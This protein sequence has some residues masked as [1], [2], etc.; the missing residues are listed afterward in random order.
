MSVCPNINLPE[1][2]ALEKEFGRYQAYRDFVESGY[3]IRT[4]QQVQNK[5]DAEK[6]SKATTPRLP[7]TK[8]IM[9]GSVEEVN[10]IAFNASQIDTNS[11]VQKMVRDSQITRAMEIARKLSENLGVNFNIISGER[12]T[13]ITAGSVNPWSGQ[14]A[15]YYGGVAYFVGDTLSLNSVLHEFAHPLVRQIQLENPTLFN[16]LYNKVSSTKEGRE[17]IEKLATTHPK[18]VPGDMMYAEEVLVQ[19][20]EHAATKQELTPSFI[21]AIKDFLF[22]LKKVLRNALGQIDVSKLDQNTTLEELA[23]MLRNDKFQ[24]DTELVTEEDVV[25]YAQSFQQEINELKNLDKS[26]IQDVIRDGYRIASRQLRQLQEDKNYK[27]LARILKNQ[28]QGFDMETIMQDLSKYQKEIDNIVNNAI[29][30]MEL[31][32]NQSTAVVNTVYNLRTI[33]EKIEAHM[34]DI[35]KNQDSKENLQKAV[36]YKKIVDYWEAFIDDLDTALKDPE[37][38]VPSNAKIYDVINNIRGRFKSINELTNT[39]MAN[40]ARDTLYEEFL[41]IVRDAEERYTQIISDLKKRGAPQRTI[42]KWYREYYGMTEAEHEVYKELND[43][44]N[45]GEYMSKSDKANYASLRLMSA[46]GIELTK[47]KMEDLLK[48]NIKD[49]NWLNSFMEGYM[50]NNDPVIG[51]LALYVKNRMNE[52]YVKAQAKMNAFSMDIRD[53]LKAMGYNPHNIGALG[54]VIMF[55]DNI[56]KEENGKLVAK[57]IW[58]FLN[59]FK[60]YRYDLRI[61]NR[62]VMDAEEEYSA[63]GSD[64]TLSR[65]YEAIVKRKDFMRKYFH[66]EFK[67][68]FYER[69]KIFEKFPNDIVGAIAQQRR[70]DVIDK[71]RKESI[72]ADEPESQKNLDR[73]WREYR[74]IYSL[75]DEFGNTKEGN[76]LLISERLREYR[77]ASRDFFEWYERPGVFQNILHAKEDELA[78]KYGVG[79]DEYDRLRDAWILKNTRVIIKPEFYAERQDILDKINAIL[80]TLPDTAQKEIDL[81]PLHQA[82]IDIKSGFRDDNGQPNPEEMTP[83]ARARIKFL[84]EE[85]EKRKGLYR[86]ISGLNKEQSERLNELITKK[87]ESALT[88]LEGAEFAGLWQMKRMGQLSDYQRR[89]LDARYK[90]LNDLSSNDATIYYIDIINNYLATMDTTEFE[91]QT[92]STIIDETSAHYMLSPVIV[93]NLKAQ[94]PEFAKWYDANHI[95]YQTREGEMFKRVSIWS[96]T[97]PNNPNHYETTKIKDRTGKVTDVIQGK[98]ALKFYRQEVKPE[99]QNE[100]IVG[101][102]VDNRGHFLPKGINDLDKSLPEWDKYVNY[103]YYELK[104][105]NPR[106]FTVLEKSVRYHLDNQQGMNQRDKLYLDFPRYTKGNYE[107]IISKSINERGQRLSNGV[108]QLAKRVRETFQKVKDDAEQGFSYKNENNLV[109]L[110][111]FDD[112]LSNVPVTGLYDIEVDNVSTDVISG[113]NRYMLGAEKQKKLIE[114]SPLARA[115][116]D[117]VNDPANSGGV[118]EQVKKNMISRFLM[119]PRRKKD[120]TVRARAINNFI[121]R[122]FE[123]ITM[124]G[125][126]SDSAALNKVANVLF[127]NASFQFFALNIPSAMKNHF[128]AKFQTMIESSAGQYLNPISA[129]KGEAWA[130]MAM[131]DLSFGGNLYTKGPKSLTQ[132]II[133]VFDPAQ[134]RLENDFRVSSMSRT[135]TKDVVEGSWLYSPRKWLELQATFQLF[136]GMMYHKKIEQTLPNG[137]KKMINYI[138]AWQLNDKNQIVLKEGIDPKW[139]ITYDDEGN[140]KM[141]TE[142]SLFKN[143]VHQVTNNLQGAYS[144]FDQPEAQRYVAFR[145]IS[146]LRRYFTPM[147]MNRFGYAGPLGKARPRLNPGLGEPAMGYYIRTLQ[148]LKE[149]VTQMGKNVPYMTKEESRAMMKTFSEFALLLLVSAI[150]LLA[151]GWDPDEDDEDRYKR[152]RSKSGAMPFWGIVDDDDRPF[153]S[154]GWLELHA[155]NLM[156]Q[157]RAENEQFIPIPEK[158]LGFGGVDNYLEMLDLKSIVTGPTTDTALQIFDDAIAILRNEDS[159]YYS[160]D[161]GPYSFQKKGGWKLSA[162]LAKMLGFTGS[163][164]DPANAIQK[165]YQA[166]AMVKR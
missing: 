142:F 126:G 45:K 93:N 150:I 13:E 161:V 4:V 163:T 98:P 30:E 19:A 125:W 46:N 1:W 154:A 85:I 82:I 116:Q 157:I 95:S 162:K 27:E 57:K 55:K 48:N 28:Y 23:S 80:S 130:S 121:E 100:R 25:A 9:S 96:V 138:D 12:A 18:L 24:I 122:E 159:A 102:T 112:E 105:K 120:T 101:V 152:L 99:F 32:T 87:N 141:G 139:G 86:G 26:K 58:T 164:L 66:Q 134:G 53:D 110:D 63:K 35:Y 68:E 123:G 39:M 90:E 78:S 21:Q 119:P 7:H 72:T 118:V 155:L 56:A 107:S 127:K 113:L 47:E 34:K 65:L 76:E 91:K 132:Q 124:K 62:A 67:P 38:N 40:G 81:A 143:K 15:F 29:E 148:V 31:L 146:Y 131:A 133:Q 135:L 51:G 44:Y 149:T 33:V 108:T 54:E 2:K 52:V 156:I 5:L 10:M 71:I 109:Y 129:G 77:E 92:G 43:K 140:V 60:D 114:I 115:I 70:N 144:E 160:R 111:M 89:E 8:G 83:E 36:Y 41:P 16:N 94:S 153:N 151:F 158:L 49:A 20:L 22:A 75:Y 166:M 137:S 17:I 42:D 145:F 165:F 136:G 59:P 106:A 147:V 14:A 64:E 3:E 61:L 117:V 11:A 69:E 79:S 37:A 74:Q 103:Q 104:E 84:E 128:G 50:Y 6:I 97:R 73:L 88:D